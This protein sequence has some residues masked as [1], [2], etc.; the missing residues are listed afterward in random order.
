MAKKKILIFISHYLP[1]YKMGGPLN[2][3][4][5]IVSNLSE[6][7]DFY[8]ITSNRDFGDDVPYPNVVLNQWTNVSG[9]KVLYIR[10]GVKGLKDILFAINATKFDSIYLNSLFDVKFSIYIVFLRYFKLLTANKIILAPR[11]ELYKEAL[12]FKRQ[13][14]FLYLK[15]IRYF[16]IY[17]NVCWHSSVESETDEIRRYFTSE[18]DIIKAGVLADISNNLLK[19]K[20]PLFEF[21]EDTLKLIF[22]SRISKDKNIIFTFDVLEKVT[23][24]LEFHIYGPI[25]DEDIWQE[26]LSRM[27][28]LPSNIVVKYFGSVDRQNVKSVLSKYD[29]FFLPTHREN[30]GHIISESLSVGTPV[31]ISK[32]T[33][34]LDLEEQKLGWDISLEDKNSFVQVIESY[35]DRAP[36]CRL[37]DRQTV[38][39]HF[40]AN[41]DF[42][43]KVKEN[44][45]LFNSTL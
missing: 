16:G 40:I 24:D 23:I 20:E 6:Y 22:L 2:S 1:G 29:I 30:F 19:I 38:I 25:E 37:F 41:V 5:N 15:L 45:Y 18:A 34:W 3:V 8:I 43:S 44:I 26:C 27:K 35:N 14:K 7:F 17:K 36:E 11:G 33:P 10:D 12:G 4:Q 39:Q 13:K 9:S 42:D 21:G 32:N 31:L 28:K